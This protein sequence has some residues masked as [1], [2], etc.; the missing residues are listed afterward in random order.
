M[1]AFIVRTGENTLEA[2]RQALLAAGS[3]D[4]AAQSAAYAGGFETPEYASQS[5]GNAATTEGQIFRVPL[6]TTPQTFNWYRRLASGSELVSPLATTTQLASSAGAGAVG[7]LQSGTGAAARTVQDKLRDVVSVKDFGA[8]G[9]NSANDTAAIQA[10]ID[11]AAAAGGEVYFPVGTYRFTALTIS[12]RVALRFASGANLVKTTTTGNGISIVGSGSRIFG[13]KIEGRPRMS[14]LAACTAGAMIYCENAGQVALDV[15]IDQFPAAAYRGIELYNVSQAVLDGAVQNCVERG[16][17]AR[18]C[19]DV[20]LKPG[21]R[22]DA[23]GTVGVEMDTVSGVYGYCT[24]YGNGT[25]N[26]R[27]VTTIGSPVLADTNGFH[28]W[29][30]AIA[31]TGGA[32]NWYCESLYRSVFDAC[33]AATQSSTTTDQHGFYFKDCGGIEMSNSIAENCNGSG[34]FNDNSDIIVTGGRYNHNG[35]Q[36]GSTDR[37]GITAQGASAK[38]IIGGSA[39]VDR[40]MGAKTQTYGLNV[41]NTIARL[42]VTHSDLTDNAGAPYVISATPAEFYESGNSAG[43]SE[44]IASAATITLPWFGQRFVITGNTNIG[45]INT[46]YKGR[47]VDFM[48]TGTPSVLA[49]YGL[50]MAGNFSATANDTISFMCADG[51]TVVELSRSVNA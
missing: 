8:V 31:D 15:R 1:A 29:T 28:F 7:F 33:W 51:A 36:A 41:K 12:G 14:A 23:N 11:A 46:M 27:L 13:I 40:F 20:T 3:A 4:D 50:V 9:N 2:A 43:E 34:L 6:G 10:A 35:V 25:N 42:K 45:T 48:F 17:Y 18:D 47:R 19:L 30:G 5:A 44:N 21:S 24:A 39:L 16:L 37:A 49:G 26:Y 32:H 38:L 22:F